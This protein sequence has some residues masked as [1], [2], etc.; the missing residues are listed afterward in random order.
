MNSRESCWGKNL[1]INFESGAFNHSATLPLDKHWRFRLSEKSATHTLL[2]MST[3]I[4][5]KTPGIFRRGQKYTGRVRI[6]KKDVW[7]ALGEDFKS[8]EAKFVVEKQQRLNAAKGA[9]YKAGETGGMKTMG[10]CVALLRKR[11]DDHPDWSDKYRA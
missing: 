6:G 1:N 2:H 4:A 7:F 3:L 10:N 9:A 11:I 5:T 8:A